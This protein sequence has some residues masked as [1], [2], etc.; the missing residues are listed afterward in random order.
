MRILITAGPTRE[1][2]DPV[3][4]IS[5]RSSGKM[6]YAIAQSARQRG[7]QVKLV[8]GPVHLPVP[9][10]VERIMVESAGE[11]LA[12]VNA[13]LIACDVLIMAAAVADWKPAA[14][15]SQKLKK[16]DAASTLELVR[17]P[18]ILQTIMPLKNGKIF[19]GFAAETENLHQEAR[20]KMAAKQLDLM[21]A[22]DVSRAD[23]GFEV[24][25]NQVV[26]FTPDGNSRELPLMSKAAVAD[27]I[28]AWVESAYNAG[29]VGAP[30]STI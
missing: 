10:G 18:D 6:G 12:A 14:A 8:S 11:M 19:V 23:A 27:E 1:R 9:E 24:D 22:N 5:N 21:V 7:H 15:S 25:T 26:F 20:R 2:I 16:A 17:T 29:P 28:M 3:R 30:H 4:F 13:G